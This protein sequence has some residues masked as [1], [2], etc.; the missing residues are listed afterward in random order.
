MAVRSSA[1]VD[2]VSIKNFLDLQGVKPVKS[3]KTFVSKELHPAAEAYRENHRDFHL[4]PIQVSGQH[5]CFPVA[6]GPDLG[7][8]RNIHLSDMPT[9]Y[10]ITVF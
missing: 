3:A 9:L 1:V 10:F 7:A 4:H 2:T 5:A 6:S 8:D